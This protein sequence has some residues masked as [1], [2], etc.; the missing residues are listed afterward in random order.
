MEELKI[1]FIIKS[2]A[3]CLAGM[4]IPCI[5]CVCGGYPDEVMLSRWGFVAQFIGSGILGTVG[6]GGSVVYDI[7][8][9]GLR[10]ATFI[11]YLATISVFSICSLALGWFTGS[12]LLISII[13]YS[14]VY[15]IIWMVEYIA[16]KREVRA[17]NLELETLLKEQKQ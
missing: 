6:L 8:S 10:K 4:L 1:K 9:W 17:M 16:W 3:G 5:I 12:M 11:H 7:E 13:P 14:L 2:L 15:F